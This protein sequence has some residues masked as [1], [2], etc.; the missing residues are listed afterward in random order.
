MSL[1][2]E[3]EKYDEFEIF[4]FFYWFSIFKFMVFLYNR[5]QMRWKTARIVVSVENC[6]CMM[7]VMDQATCC[8]C[9]ANVSRETFANGMI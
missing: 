4:H 1:C 5:M 9:F 8:F 6:L 2:R 3:I 7:Y